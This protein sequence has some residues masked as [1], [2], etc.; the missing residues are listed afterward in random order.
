M[1]VVNDLPECTECYRI[2]EDHERYVIHAGGL[3]GA[4]YGVTALLEAYGFRFFHPAQTH[5]P[6]SLTA[7]NRGAFGSVHKPEQTKRGLHLHTLHPIEACFDFWEPST[8]HLANAQRT[9]DWLVKNRGNYVEWAALDGIQHDPA[10]ATAW[11]AHTKQIIEYAHQRGVKAGLSIQLFGQSNLQKAFDLLE[12][13]ASPADPRASMRARLELPL[14]LGF[15]TL[16]MSF[17]EFSGNDSQRFID[18]LNDVYAA[19]TGLSPGLEVAATIHVGK[20]VTA[21]YDGKEL[22]YY[23][24]I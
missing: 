19:A 13:Q 24:L 12:T 1:L 17:G 15:D 4:Q 5:V 21:T 11:A 10:R 23:F 20:D 3:L 9:I 18:R 22:L 7:P 16:N 8:E 14:S 2:N 6:A